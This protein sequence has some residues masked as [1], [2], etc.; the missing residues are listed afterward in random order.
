MLLKNIVNEFFTLLGERGEKQVNHELGIKT[1]NSR[2]HYYCDSRCGHS[3]EWFH[4][5]YWV[6][7]DTDVLIVNQGK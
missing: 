6:N 5:G 2:P 3:G 4:R 1:I 7:A